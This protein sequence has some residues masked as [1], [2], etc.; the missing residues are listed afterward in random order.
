MSYWYDRDHSSLVPEAQQHEHLRLVFM[1]LNLAELGTNPDPKNLA[2]VIM[3]VLKRIISPQGGPYLLI[4]WTQIGSKVDDVKQVLYERLEGVPPPLDVVELSKRT[5][6]PIIKPEGKDLDAELQTLFGDL[7]KTLGPMEQEVRKLLATRP[8]LS[9]VAGWESRATEAAA[10]AVNE[11]TSQARADIDK[12][13]ELGESI[14]RVLTTIA[15]G[16][17]GPAQAEVD[18]ARSLD[19]G[20]V[21]LLN[22]QFSMSASNQEYSDNVKSALGESLKQK[23]K[24]SDGRRMAAALNTFFQIDRDVAKTHTAERGVVI[25]GKA[26]FTEQMLGGTHL[27]LLRDHF[28]LPQKPEE[29]EKL[30]TA[31]G[32]ASEVLLIEVGA[33]CDHAQAKPRTLRY[34]VGFEIPEKYI[35]LVLSKKNGRLNHDA[36]QLLGPWNLNGSAFLLVSCRRFFTWQDS[37]PPAGAVKYRLRSSVVN[38]L[39]HHY[40]TVSSRPGIIEFH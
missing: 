11:I 37:K 25:P 27:D 15:R 24:F 30:V 4:F 8:E 36:L 9:V 16:A 7:V 3:G 10:R 2:G 17:V 39:L 19:A 14:K 23:I 1:D 35:D 26:L 29:T 33:D 5:F 22:D 20:M 13:Q 21:E 34:L 6:M 31:L 12:P 40:S 38:K 18:P 32:E 28:M